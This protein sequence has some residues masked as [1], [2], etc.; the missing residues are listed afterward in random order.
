[1]GLVAGDA[2]HALVELSLLK[3]GFLDGHHVRVELG[4]GPEEVLLH[5]RAQPVDVP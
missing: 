4:D 2:G 1:V 3:L 5:G